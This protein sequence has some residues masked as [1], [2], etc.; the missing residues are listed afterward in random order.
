MN[1]YKFL[2]LSSLFTL[3]LAC[4]GSEVDKKA[5][6]STAVASPAVKAAKPVQNSVAATTPEATEAEKPAAKKM[7]IADPAQAGGTI[8]LSKDA[9]PK[10]V[11]TEPKKE[12]TKTV[13]KATMTNEVAKPAKTT[14][15][16]APATE[17]AEPDMPASP[18]YPTHKSW[19]DLLVAHV[20]PSGTVD[21]SGLKQNEKKLDE[22]L[23]ILADNHPNTDWN[24][25]ESKAYWLNAYNAF[26]VKL[27]LDNYPVKKITD[28]H[29]G[30]PWDLKWIKLGGNTYSLNQIEHSII[31]PRYKD[32]RIHFAVNCAAQSCPPLY[33]RAFK[34]S[35]LSGTLTALTKAF[36]NN[37]KYNDIS[38]DKAVISKI[39]EWYKDDF[40][41]LKTYINKYSETSLSENA[42][43]EFKDYNWALNGK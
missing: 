43:I 17:P 2:L 15:A 7:R 37:T 6:S 31:R 33:N 26:T 18:S 42:N 12:Q 8:R 39:F 11:K 41:E 23:K 20:S 22:Y 36:V 28:L 5:T 21:Y 32:A 3:L 4:N 16:T 27:I 14:A 30:K 35:N 10:S 24:R 40:G 13:A 1:I 29:G 19:N 9:P 25:N 38:A 34:A